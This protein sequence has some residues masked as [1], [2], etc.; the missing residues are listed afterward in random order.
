[1]SPTVTKKP[2]VQ[3][4]HQVRAID[5]HGHKRIVHAYDSAAAAQAA[6]EV[7]KKRTHGRYEVV[8]VNNNIHAHWGIR[9]A[10]VKK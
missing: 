4:V 1:M 3:N 8:E 9:P 2:S 6:I 7:M 10:H 5:I